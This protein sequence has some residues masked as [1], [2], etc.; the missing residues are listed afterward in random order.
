MSVNLFQ[1]NAQFPR[2]SEFGGWVGLGWLIYS[3]MV[4]TDGYC[5]YRMKMSDNTGSYESQLLNAP[6]CAAFMM[7]SFTVPSSSL[8]KASV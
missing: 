3:N 1:E 5:M 8:A 2:S 6:D 7:K 4:M